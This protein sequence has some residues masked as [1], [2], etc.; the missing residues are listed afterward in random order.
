MSE[1]LR[2]AIPGTNPAWGVNRLAKELYDMGYRLESPARRSPGALYRNPTTGETV[3]LM[4]RQ[5]HRL[6][7]DP[8]EKHY[9]KYY[10]RY[11]VRNWSDE[12]RHT[13]VP[14]KN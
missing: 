10:Y 11:R 6:G 9:L 3:R 13:P 8:P 12:G 5:S 7:T 2:D 1:I 4:E 14:D